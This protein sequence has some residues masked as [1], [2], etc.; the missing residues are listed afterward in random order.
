MKREREGT[1]SD[2]PKI[3]FRTVTLF[4]LP[5]S[6]VLGLAIADVPLPGRTGPWKA[7][8]QF[9]VLPRVWRYRGRWRR[10]RS[11]WF[12]MWG[13]PD[14]RRRKRRK[15]DRRLPLRLAPTVSWGRT[16]L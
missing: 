11:R 13:W 7:Q 16:T 12:V 14:T 4:G 5:G 9:G 15:R 2:Q 1:M 10:V 3:T 8:V 6:P